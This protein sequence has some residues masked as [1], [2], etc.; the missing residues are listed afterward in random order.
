MAF[1]SFERD[2]SAIE[3]LEDAL[4]TFETMQ[5]EAADTLTWD[6]WGYPTVL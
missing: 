3:L 4:I 6:E 5:F 1:Q 2:E